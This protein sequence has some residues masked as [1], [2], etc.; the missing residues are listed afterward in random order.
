MSLVITYYYPV[1]WNVGMVILYVVITLVKILGYGPI[2]AGKITR[3]GS[4]L[5]HAIVR[6]VNAN[7]NREIA[8]KVTSDTGGYFILVP[9]GDYYVTIE[10]KNQDGTY[11]KIATSRTIHSQDGLI[12]ASFDL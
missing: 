1:W 10:M 8:H 6:V 4:P 3:Y 9:K 11:T 5:A 2:T 12:N 7:L